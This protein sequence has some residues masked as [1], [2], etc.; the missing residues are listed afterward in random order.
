M[1]NASLHNISHKIHMQK[2][3][4]YSWVNFD[5][6]SYLMFKYLYK[7]TVTILSQTSTQ[8]NNNQNKDNMKNVL[9]PSSNSKK[10]EKT[11]KSKC[12]NDPHISAKLKRLRISFQSLI[13]FT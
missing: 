10:G 8:K 2:L 9:S 12:S 13:S 1:I 11:L 5:S 6:K 3:Y 7:S 4:Y